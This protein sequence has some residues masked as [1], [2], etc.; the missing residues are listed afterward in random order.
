MEEYKTQSVALKYEIAD[1]VSIYQKSSQGNTE[2]VP[3]EKIIAITNEYENGMREA[4]REYTHLA[5]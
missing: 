3:V 1:M 4:N 2:A 5:E